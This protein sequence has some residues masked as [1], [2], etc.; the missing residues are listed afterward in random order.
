MEDFG[1]LAVKDSEFGYETVDWAAEDIEED[2][3]RPA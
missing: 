1:A 3:G 2:I